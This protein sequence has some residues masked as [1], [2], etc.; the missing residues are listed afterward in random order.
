MTYKT[1]EILPYNPAWPQWFEVVKLQLSGCL[2]NLALSIDHIG[3]TSVPGL[4]AKDRIDVQV[5]VGEITLEMKA[6]VDCAFRGAGLG[7]TEFSKDHRP[8]LDS[9]SEDDWQKLYLS[10]MK[11]TPGCS[12]Y[13]NI[14]IRT[15]GNANQIYPLLFRDYLRSH[16]S[17]AA[18]YQQMKE[19][20]AEYHPHN[21]QAYCE[22]K[23]PACDIIM[24]AAQDWAM[25]VSWRPTV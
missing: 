21:I 3:S 10:F 22:I 15:K 7:E 4:G 6:S 11:E 1:I 23:D 12:F 8:P 16:P 17:A 19:K 14:H 25:R 18:A 20:L 2:G 5:T 9:H 24:T 13:S